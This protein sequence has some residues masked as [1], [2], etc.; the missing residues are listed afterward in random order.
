MIDTGSIVFK[1]TFLK[2]VHFWFSAAVRLL[3][4]PCVRLLV[5][6]SLFLL[7]ESWNFEHD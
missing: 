5:F 1:N 7:L 2:N 3:V 6:V 4:R